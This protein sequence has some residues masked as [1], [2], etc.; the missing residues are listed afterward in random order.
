[1]DKYAE[2]GDFRNFLKIV[3]LILGLAPGLR[4]AIRLGA[5]V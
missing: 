4:D 2:E 5:W 3:I 1:M